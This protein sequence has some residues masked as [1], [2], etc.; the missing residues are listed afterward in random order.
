MRS[1]AVRAQAG[2]RLELAA[3]L[4]ARSG[5]ELVLMQQPAES[6]APADVALIAMRGDGSRL[7]QRRSLLK[8]AMRPMRVLVGAVLA[9]HPLQV[10][11]RDDQDPVQT[12]APDA[13]DPALGV[14]L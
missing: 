3:A 4:R 11:A 6:L 14:R 9:Q 1:A 8:G 13:A 10:L 5:G 2:G 12:L 7:E